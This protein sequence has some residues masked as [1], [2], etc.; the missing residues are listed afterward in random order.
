MK[1]L[2]KN[3][4][5]FKTGN[6]LTASMKYPGYFKQPLGKHKSKHC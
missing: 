6:E 1:G 4:K 3:S 2:K 5:K